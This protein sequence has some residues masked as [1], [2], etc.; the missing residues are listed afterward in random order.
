[1]GNFDTAA[2][3]AEAVEEFATA[4]GVA[5]AGRSDAPRAADSVRVG[6]SSVAR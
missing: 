4:I 2:Y 6:E 1:V 5:S 3:N